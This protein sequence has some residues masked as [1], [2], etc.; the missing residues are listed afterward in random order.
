MRVLVFNAGSSSL[1]FD[2]FD[3]AAGQE[4]VRLADGEVKSIGAS[5]ELSFR[6]V[7]GAPVVATEQLSSHGDAARRAFDLLAGTTTGAI[8]AVGHRVVHGGS[9]FSRPTRVDGGVLAAIEAVSGFAPLHNAAALAVMAVARERLPATVPMVATFDTAFFRELPEVAA[10]YPLPR[11]LAQRHGIR[12]FGFHGLAHHFMAERFA[13]R[14]GQPGARLITL[15][16]GSGWSA[17]ATA[18]GRPLD[19]SMGFTPLEGLMM[20][21]RSGD[22]D[23]SLP[24]VLAEKEGA[25]LKDVDDWLNTHAGLLGVS[26]LSGD[27]RDLLKAEREGEANAA[28]ALALFCYRIRKYVGAYLAVLGGADGLVFGGGIGENSPEIRARCCAG[29][30]WAGI[31]IDAGLNTAATGSE[32]DITAADAATRCFVLPV[33]EA[34]LIAKDTLACLEAV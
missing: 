8:D 25:S 27:V 10:T 26:G 5:A 18:G 16:L 1:K 6:S 15:Q 14:T 4:P 34:S 3:G 7:G 13:E 19:T 22:I 29:L 12:R 17:T 20:A 23:P 32:A 21:T 2:L 33:D 31:G 28:L 30:E 9:A 24:A 11:D